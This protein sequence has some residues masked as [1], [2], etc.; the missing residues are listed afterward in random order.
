MGDPDFL[1]R[2]DSGYI[3]RESKMSRRVNEKDH[4]EILLQLQTY[5]WL[6]QNT[7]GVPAATL[8]VHNGAGEIVEVPRIGAAILAELSNLK[9]IKER[10]VEP[11][12]A[13]GW[14]KCDSCPFRS[15]C[16]TQAE[17]TRAAALIY[18]VDEGLAA[19]LH[20]QGTD[21]VEQLLSSFSEQMLSEF[22]R[23]WGA[24][25]QRVGKT[26]AQI[27]VMARALASGKEIILQTPQI[28]AHDNYVMFDLEG[29]PPQLDE[30]DKVYLWGM[31]VFGKKPSSYL[32]A[33]AAFGADGEREGWQQ[34]LR[35]ARMLFAEYG[36]IPFVHWAA[37]E[38]THIKTCI[39][40]YGDPDSIGQ[41]VIENLL[42]LLPVTRQA[43]ALPLPSYSLKVVEKYVGFRRTQDEYGGDWSMA[44]FI[45]ATEMEDE[46]ERADVMDLILKYNE[47]DLAATWAVLNWLRSIRLN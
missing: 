39:G 12:S 36:E 9:Q 28:P 43:I 29:M 18:G 45:E 8:E 31:Q 22:K 5:G 6:Y 34:F 1:I 26:A 33:V 40:R 15:H 2:Q 7:F 46:R 20:A 11:F 17:E 47:E 16:W 37:Y 25:M 4:P 10:A 3:I 35:L 23:P 19:A 21:T 30:L 14:S 13:V 24:R 42:D 41:R 32:P 44:K 38:P 27:M